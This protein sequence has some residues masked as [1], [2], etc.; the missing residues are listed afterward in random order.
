[1]SNRVT[2]DRDREAILLWDK[3]SR[4]WVDQSSSITAIYKAFY[5]KS[6]SGYNIY[7]K[8]A[9]KSY[10]FKKENVK[11]RSK[12]SPKQHLQRVSS[13]TKPLKPESVKTTEI[14]NFDQ[15][16]QILQIQRCIS[17][18]QGLASYAQ[19]IAEKESPLY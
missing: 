14:N 15:S 12:S 6:H 18:Y 13:P 7:F 16:D 3:E 11:F 19:V 10:F 9:Q 5:Y 17:Y 2:F 1:M 4:N 8:G